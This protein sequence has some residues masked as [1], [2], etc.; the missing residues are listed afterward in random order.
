MAPQLKA[1]GYDLFYFDAKKYGE[2]YFVVSGGVHTRLIAVKSGKDYKKHSALDKIR[3][4]S[5][6]T[7]RDSIVLFKGNLEVVDDVLYLPWYTM[8]A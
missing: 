3:S 7:F 4:V 6:W 5:E 2:V 1:N 8:S